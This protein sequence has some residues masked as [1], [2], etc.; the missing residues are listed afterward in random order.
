MAFFRR[1]SSLINPNSTKYFGPGSP[2]HLNDPEFY[3]EENEDMSQLV[4][5]SNPNSLEN[6]NHAMN[7]TSKAN[8]QIVVISEAEEDLS[9]SPSVHVAAREQQ[10]Y[11]RKDQQRKQIAISL[12]NLKLNHPELRKFNSREDLVKGYRPWFIWTVSLI[13]VAMLVYE[14]VLNNALFGQFIQ[15]T[16]SFNILIGPNTLVRVF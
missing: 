12:D 2:H 6:L 10:N 3:S 7:P 11:T 9:R 1:A 14:L 15:T 4:F 16:P 5:Y 13:Q 8:T